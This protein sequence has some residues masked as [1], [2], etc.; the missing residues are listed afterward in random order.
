MRQSACFVAAIGLLVSSAAMGQTGSKVLKDKEAITFNEIE[1]GFYFGLSAAPY[2]YFLLNAPSSSGN[3]PFS[4][5]QAAQVEL[6]VEFGD[7]LSVGLFVMGTANRA[8]SDYIGRSGGLASGD[9]SSLVPGAAARVGI[10]GFNDS[11]DVQRTWVYARLGAGYAMFAPKALL[12]DGDIY[13]FLGLGLEYFTRL[14]HFSIGLEVMAT[15]L[16]MNTSFG[17]AITPNLRYSF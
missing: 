6:G 8:G 1:H 10:I 9:F 3:G 14:R 5:G 17:F 13:A 11:Q 4:V 15:G 2:T 12:P 7:R 16:I